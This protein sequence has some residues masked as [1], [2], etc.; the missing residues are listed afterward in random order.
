MNAMRSLYNTIKRL[1]CSISYNELSP[2]QQVDYHFDLSAL[3]EYERISADISDESTLK[4][5]SVPS[6]APGL[7]LFPSVLNEKARAKWYRYFME[8]VPVQSSQVLRS[9]VTLPPENRE[10]LRWLTFG[11]HYNWSMKCYR[12]EERNAI[13]DA[14]TELLQCLA[15]LLNLKQ[16]KVEAGIVN[17][18]TCKSRLG[19]HVDG[20]ERNVSVPL[21]SLSLGSDGIFIIDRTAQ[22]DTVP[23]SV[24]LKDGDLMIL[25]GES[26]LLSHA[27]PKV[28]CD[29]QSCSRR[30]IVRIN[31]N[32]RQFNDELCTHRVAG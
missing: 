1:P 20:H 8:E 21:L 13:P 11:Y 32:A 9:N 7:L 30:K 31:V 22:G 29:S 18:Y 10:S 4:C 16:W 24:L 19:P 23:A 2:L 12:E 28:Y 14:M 26:R 27:L 17:Y 5:F 3:D 25:S 6:A 15:H